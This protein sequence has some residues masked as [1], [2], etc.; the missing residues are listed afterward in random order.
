MKLEQLKTFISGKKILFF[1]TKDLSYLRNVQERVFLENCDG[2]LRIVGSEHKSYFIRVLKVYLVGIV[3]M[4]VFRPKVIFAGFAPQ[5]LLPFLWF[6][7]KIHCMVVID[8]FISLYDTMIDDRKRFLPGSRVAKILHWL[9]RKTL[10]IA[11]IY[12][13]DTAADRTFFSQ[14]FNVELEKGL[15]WYLCADCS[16]YFPMIQKKASEW[17]T[18]F[19]VLYFGSILPLQGVEVVLDAVSQLKDAKWL[20]FILVGPIEKVNG[21]DRLKFQKNVVCYSWLDQNTLAEKISMADLCLAGHFNKEIGKAKRTIPGKA[22]IY[23]AMGKSMVLGDSPANHELY[24][25]DG[26]K[27]YFVPQGDAAALAGK[28]VE[29]AQK[30][31]F[32]GEDE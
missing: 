24:R 15:V 25:E 18:K 8:F 1:T 26:K 19:I 13:A 3:Q 29:L 30:G 27:I 9:D 10:K 22:Y 14:E 5:L 11:D 21:A 16:I 2:E 32:L 28:I 31:G 4:F 7:R 17:K 23:A 20:Q 6:A 12:I